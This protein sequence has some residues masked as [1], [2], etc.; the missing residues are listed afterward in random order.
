M[1]LLKEVIENIEKEYEIVINTDFGGFFLNEKTCTDLG[2]DC[3]QLY[4]FRNDRANPILVDYLKANKQIGLEIVRI[5]LGDILR[6]YIRD[7]DGR[8]EIV[9]VG[10]DYSSSLVSFLQ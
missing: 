10:D 3:S 2:L 4:K 7:Y 9:Y 1:R 5:S 6:A 8:E